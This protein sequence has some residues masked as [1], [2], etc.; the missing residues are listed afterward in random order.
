MK[1]PKNY[2]QQSLET[3]EGANWGSPAEAPTN[4]IERCLT[5]RKV[6]LENFLPE[7]L[8]ILIGQDIGLPFLMPMALD[9]LRENIFL[10]TE[11]L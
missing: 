7:D 2:K 3:L 4:L 9:V 1:L 11:L 6:P 10:E 5:L 8:R